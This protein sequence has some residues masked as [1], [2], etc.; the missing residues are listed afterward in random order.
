MSTRANI[1]IN[2]GE[3]KI[4][5]YRHYDGYPTVTGIDI[6]NKIKRNTD[7]NGLVSDLLSESY[8]GGK[9]VYEITN[10]IHGDI[11]YDYEINVPKLSYN[12]KHKD[13]EG[14]YTSMPKITIKERKIIETYEDGVR[15]YLISW[16]T[17]HDNETYEDLLPIFLRAKDKQDVDF[18]SKLSPEQL[19]FYKVDPTEIEEARERLKK[20]QY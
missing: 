15:D 8:E 14:K 17:I 3:S 1:T 20:N 13:V 16:T 12:F 4:I 2:K 7:T 9:K 18:Y 10:E 11:E 5:L 19:K 6:L